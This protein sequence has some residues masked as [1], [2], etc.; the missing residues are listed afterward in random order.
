MYLVSCLG[1]RTGS[2]MSDSWMNHSFKPILYNESVKRFAKF[3]ESVRDSVLISQFTCCFTLGEY[4]RTQ[5][6][7]KVHNKVD[8]YLPVIQ[9]V[10]AASYCL[11]AMMIKQALHRLQPA[12]ACE[13]TAGK[14]FKTHT[15]QNTNMKTLWWYCSCFTLNVQWS[16]GV[17][18]T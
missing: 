5:R 1:I 11:P 7:I 18:L 4:F 8:I 10:E 3:S 12:H 6:T 17:T 2:L 9:W 13:R 16:F 14:R 15:H